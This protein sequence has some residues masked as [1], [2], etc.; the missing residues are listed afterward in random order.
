MV[1]VQQRGSD[2]RPGDL[3][4]GLR[5]NGAGRALRLHLES[6]PLGLAPETSVIALLI[7]SLAGERAAAVSTGEPSAQ[8]V[9]IVRQ[10][11][12]PVM[13]PAGQGGVRGVPGG[14]VHQWRCRAEYPHGRIAEAKGGIP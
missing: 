3:F 13:L 4:D 2:P 9:R 11:S 8:E 6:S 7:D 1:V 5:R 12:G 10:P 14:S